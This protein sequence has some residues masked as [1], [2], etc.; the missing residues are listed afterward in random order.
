MVEE[1]INCSAQTNGT[2]CKSDDSALAVMDIARTR[3]VLCENSDYNDDLVMFPTIEE[4]L[5]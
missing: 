2:A 1:L 5:H 4:T 3:E